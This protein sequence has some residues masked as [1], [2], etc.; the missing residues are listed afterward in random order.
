MVRR[1]GA[2]G[3][4]IVV[5]TAIIPLHRHI[6]SGPPTATSTRWI[7]QADSRHSQ[8]PPQVALPAT[9]TAISTQSL[10]ICWEIQ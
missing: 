1:E 8:F 6:H 3:L 10:P 5:F 4:T 9:T 2:L 7:S